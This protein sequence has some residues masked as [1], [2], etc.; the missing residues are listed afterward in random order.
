MLEKKA[1]SFIRRLSDAIQKLRN[2]RP[3]TMLSKPDTCVMLS[4]ELS[5]DVPKVYT[6]VHMVR[7]AVLFKKDGGLF[8]EQ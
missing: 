1:V 2:R 7:A 3:D 5:L 6:W 4:F 8:T